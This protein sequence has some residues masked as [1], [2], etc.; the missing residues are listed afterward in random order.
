[1]KFEEISDSKLLRPGEMILHTPTHTIVVYAALVEDTVRVFANGALLEDE[2]A[3]FKKIVLT[4][5]QY[6]AGLQVSRCKGCGS[7]KK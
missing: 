3:N 7:K 2:L 6:R 4:K 5:K 1:M